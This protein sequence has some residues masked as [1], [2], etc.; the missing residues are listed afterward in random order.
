MLRFFL[1]VITWPICSLAPLLGAALIGGGASLL[2]GLL[3]NAANAKQVD[4]QTEFQERMSRTSHQREVEDLR[5]AGL[6]PILSGT[7]GMGASTPPGASMPQHD[8][9]SPAVGSAL[10]AARTRADMDILES[11]KEAIGVA[12][13][14]DAAQMKL[15]NKLADK[16][17]E[18]TAAT[19]A[20][21]R[22][23]NNQADTEAERR[24]T[25][26]NNARWR[27]YEAEMAGHTAKGVKLEGE[28]DDTT[29]GKV[30]RY[31][32]RAVKSATGGSSAYRNYRGRD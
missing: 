18:D 25:E 2:G 10:A 19:K 22:L 24:H 30:M 3:T 5:A 16:A 32:D 4:Q 11:Q 28:I 9:V 14:R 27:G 17:I 15:N 12:A 1:A 23:I 8:V 21:I 29:Y 6:N 31:I 7:G 13:G 20:S 26:R